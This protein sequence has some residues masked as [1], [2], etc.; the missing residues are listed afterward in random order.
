[1]RTILKIFA[2]A[3]LTI[4]ISCEDLGIYD[5]DD[6]LDYEPYDTDIEIR[7]TPVIGQGES[8]HVKV[9]KGRIEDNILIDERY[10]WDSYEIYGKISQEYSAI[11]TCIRN[12]VQYNAVN[13][14]IPRVISKDDFCESVCFIVKDEEIDLRLRYL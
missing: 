10:A 11:A 8:Y 1:M 13:G 3:L 7:L 9:Y 12:G 6:C 5:C 14:T 4:S 2:L